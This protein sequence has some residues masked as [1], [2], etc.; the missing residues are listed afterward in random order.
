MSNTCGRVL[1]VSKR[2]CIRKEGVPGSSPN[3]IVTKM[4]SYKKKK[5]QCIQMLN[6]VA[7]D[8]GKLTT[9]QFVVLKQ[10]KKEIPT[11]N[12]NQDE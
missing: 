10:E 4:F 7:Q 6:L 12:P 1:N 8:S 9:T 2:Q 5:Y 3:G 11:S